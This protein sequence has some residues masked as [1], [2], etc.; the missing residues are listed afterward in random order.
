MIATNFITIA[1]LFPFL[2]LSRVCFL[3]LS[4]KFTLTASTMALF[5][6][7]YLHMRATHCQ[8]TIGISWKITSILPGPVPRPL[9]FLPI[10]SLGP[11]NVYNHLLDIRISVLN[12]AILPV[13]KAWAFCHPWYLSSCLLS[14]S[15]N[16][17]CHNLQDLFIEFTHTFHSHCYLPKTGSY[18]LPLSLYSCLSFLQSIL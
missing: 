16:E 4:L 6:V 7:G 15:S 2:Q 11:H 1:K 17:V 14:Q 13:T 3:S 8:I 18:L 9:V 5:L 10:L 12:A